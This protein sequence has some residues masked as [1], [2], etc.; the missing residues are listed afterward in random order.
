MYILIETTNKII[1]SA[2]IIWVNP[3]CLAIFNSLNLFIQSPTQINYNITPGINNI[4][5]HAFFVYT[6]FLSKYI[7]NWLLSL[8]RG[9]FINSNTFMTIIRIC[10]F[11]IKSF[12][13]SQQEYFTVINYNKLVIRKKANS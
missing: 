10:K 4:H 1:T 3:I 12:K 6:Q 5:R 2:T 9:Y 13:D 7:P 8:F 11:Y